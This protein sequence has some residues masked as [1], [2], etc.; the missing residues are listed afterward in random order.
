MPIT[1]IFTLIPACNLGRMA[2][3]AVNAVA[4][5]WEIMVIK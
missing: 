3:F 4:V 5:L 1:V 2:L